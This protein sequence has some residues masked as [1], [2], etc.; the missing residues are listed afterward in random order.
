MRKF[1]PLLLAFITLG[2]SLT[3]CSDLTQSLDVVGTQSVAAF[4]AVLDV[5]AASVVF[6]EMNMGWSLT[7]PDGTAKFIWSENYA[8]SPL[9]DVMIEFDAPPF[10]AAGLDTEKLPEHIV[11]YDDKFM[12]GIKLGQDVLQYDGESSARDAYAQLVTLYRSRIGYHTALDHY[13]VDLGE[14]NLF[15]WAKDLRVNAKTKENQDKDIVFVLNPEPFIA[16]GANPNAIAG[17]NFAKVSVD[18]NG[19][20]TE[21]DK[22]LKAFDLR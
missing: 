12:V 22:L 9:H 15:E 13:N 8:L 20:P 10:L 16:A 21:V 5:A 17:W 3:A 1:F 19:K 7:A 18:I 4:G 11:Y 6:D 2:S 14:G